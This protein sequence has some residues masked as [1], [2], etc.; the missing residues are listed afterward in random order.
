MVLG[1][2]ITARARPPLAVAVALVSVFAVFHGYAHGVE[3]PRQSNAMSYGTGF[4]L[5]TG[6]IHVAGIALGQSSRLR[7]GD[8]GLRL[9]GAAIAAW[10]AVL[11]GRCW[12]ANG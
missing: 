4:V 6:L 2:A 5:A 12:I 1:L 3:M 10:G 9:V 7:H 8:A 11:A